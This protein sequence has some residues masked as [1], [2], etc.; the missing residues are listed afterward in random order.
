MIIT[1]KDLFKMAGIL[2]VAF[3]AVIVCA[4]FLNFNLD[5]L[6]LKQ[7]ADFPVY[8]PVYKIMEMNGKVI[9]GVSGEIGRASCRERV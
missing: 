6:A 1:I 5:L 2:A 3:C 8:E 4:M 7:R 9:C